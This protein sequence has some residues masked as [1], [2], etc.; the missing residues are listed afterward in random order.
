MLLSS[1]PPVPGTDGASAS[2][3]VFSK[4]ISLTFL[5]PF[6]NIFK[7]SCSF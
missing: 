3:G 1:C 2:E 6:F 7:I 4:K 5:F